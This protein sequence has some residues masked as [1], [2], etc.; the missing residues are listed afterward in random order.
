MTFAEIL[1]FIAALVIIY[2]LMTP[3]QRYLEPRLRKFFRSGLRDKG[4]PVIDITD[5]QNKKDK[6][7]S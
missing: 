5:Y 2:V 1:A 4:K 6:P 3:L 7:K